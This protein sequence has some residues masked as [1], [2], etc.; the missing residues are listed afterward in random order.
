MHPPVSDEVRYKLLAYLDQRPNAS[1]R[2]VAAQLGVSV[3][4][5]NYCLRALVEK[6]WI[7]IRRFSRS[8]KKL[9]YA[10]ILTP[11]GIEEKVAV[12][13]RFLKRKMAEYDEVSAEIERL[14]GELRRIGETDVQSSKD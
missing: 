2:E 8:E 12:T 3:G 6:G 1:Q 5:V 14:H 10:Y 13:Y 7:K 11:K 4:K 9:S